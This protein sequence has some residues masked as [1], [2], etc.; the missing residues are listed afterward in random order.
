MN[1]QEEEVNKLQSELIET[2]NKLLTA[3]NQL[4]GTFKLTSAR[5]SVGS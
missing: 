4:T 5:L 1:C 3:N 2:E